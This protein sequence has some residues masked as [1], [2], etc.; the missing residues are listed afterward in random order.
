M[1]LDLHQQ[2]GVTFVIATLLPLVS[3]LL[4]LLLFVAWGVLRPYQD[5]ATFR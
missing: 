1:P 2:P 5:W 4:I 3:F